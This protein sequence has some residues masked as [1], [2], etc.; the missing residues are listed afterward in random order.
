MKRNKLTGR[1]VPK[2]TGKKK[3]NKKLGNLGVAKPKKYKI[4]IKP[5]APKP[6]SPGGRY[7]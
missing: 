6:K 3:G 7:V 2:G 5:N 4:K 1:F